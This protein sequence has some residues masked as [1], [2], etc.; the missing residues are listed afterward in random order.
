M[1]YPVNKGEGCVMFTL[2]SDQANALS[3][4]FVQAVGGTA[5]E[6]KP[7]P[8][9]HIMW[10]QLSCVL[11]LSEHRKPEEILLRKYDNDNTVQQT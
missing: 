11:T 6:L 9:I 1:Q 8:A 7:P 2:N 4:S 5:I 10:S 3:Q